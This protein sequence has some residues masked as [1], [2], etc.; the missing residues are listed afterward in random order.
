MSL[1]SFITD[2]EW[3]PSRNR[4]VNESPFTGR[5]QHS[6]LRFHRWEFLVHYRKTKGANALALLNELRALRGGDVSF[7][8]RDPSRATPSTGYTGTGTINSSASGYTIPVTGLDA[9]TLVAKAG[10]IMSVQVGGTNWQMFT[11][12][13]NATTNGSGEVSVSVDNPVRGTAANGNAV[14]F[15]NWLITVTLE[16]NEKW[17]FDKHNVLIVPPLKFVEDF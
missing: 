6:T 16:D 14:R 9:S 8:F 2:V 11:I 12:T 7:N 10:D 1:L 3:M 4:V 5:R 17:R 13:S 15:N